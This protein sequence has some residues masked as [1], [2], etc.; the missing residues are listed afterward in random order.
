MRWRLGIHYALVDF[1]VQVLPWSKQ[2]ICR[3]VDK[4]QQAGVASTRLAKFEFTT[5]SWVS[6][7][8]ASLSPDSDRGADSG[9][10][11]DGA[12]DHDQEEDNGSDASSFSSSDEHDLEEEEVPEDDEARSLSTAAGHYLP[13]HGPGSCVPRRRW[14]DKA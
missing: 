1:R 12:S 14:S 4:L 7:R 9:S 13:T 6:H 5:S 11:S 3:D 2:K 8:V 10:C